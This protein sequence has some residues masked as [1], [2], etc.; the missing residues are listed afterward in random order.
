[1]QGVRQLDGI[2]AKA[3]HCWI[4]HYSCESFYDRPDGGTARIT[5]IA[6]RNLRSGQTHSFSIHKVAELDGIAG[7]AVREKYDDYEKRMLKDY[8]DFVKSHAGDTWLHWNMRDINYGFAAIEHRFRVLN[9]KP[10]VLSDDHKVDMARLMIDIYGVGYI[11]H[12]RL[13]NLIAH[14]KIAPIGFLSGKDEAAAF[15][16]G[17]YVKLHQSTLRKVDVLANILGRAHERRLRV[18]STWREIHGVSL[19]SLADWAGDHWIVL[20]LAILGS[21]ASIV[22]LVVAL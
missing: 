14:N 16:A 19:Q 5:S 13:T 22:A 2:F 20:M 18:L 11:G 7:Q 3:E 21:I 1:M 15:D 12:P 9:G 4:V 17:D 8:F 6:V 10:E